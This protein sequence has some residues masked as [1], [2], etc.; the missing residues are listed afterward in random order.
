M[1]VSTA[2]E[3]GLTGMALTLSSCPVTP[4]FLLICEGRS[5]KYYFQIIPPPALANIYRSKLSVAPIEEEATLV[6]LTV[7]RTGTRA[8]S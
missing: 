5:N 1:R 4:G 8:G 3:S 6:T 2:S 7:I